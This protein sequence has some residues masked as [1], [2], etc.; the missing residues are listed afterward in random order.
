V[1]RALR[2]TTSFRLR[3]LSERGRLDQGRGDHRWMLKR[4]PDWD[5]EWVEWLRRLPNACNRSPDAFC[6]WPRAEKC[7]SLFLC[8]ASPGAEGFGRSR[9]GDLFERRHYARHRTET[10]FEIRPESA[11]PPETGTRFSIP[12]RLARA[13]ST[14]PRFDSDRSR[15]FLVSWGPRTNTQHGQEDL[16]PKPHATHLTRTHSDQH[17][18]QLPPVKRIFGYFFC[19]RKK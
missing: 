12:N 19:N 4:V 2:A 7:R 13:R 16:E 11:S 17:L 8:E 6:I 1:R 18:E 5:D 3:S 15:N 14:R 9:P 10:L